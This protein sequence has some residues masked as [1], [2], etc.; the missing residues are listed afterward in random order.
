MPNICFSNYQIDYDKRAIVAR[1]AICFVNSLALTELIVILME[2]SN[3]E[4]LLFEY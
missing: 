2:K 1:T 3:T 4:I